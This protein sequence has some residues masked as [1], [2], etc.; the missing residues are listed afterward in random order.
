M[1]LVAFGLISGQHTEHAQAFWKSFDRLGN[2]TRAAAINQLCL[3]ALMELEC[4]R[5]APFEC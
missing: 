4:Y 2:R 5:F 3:I 1:N